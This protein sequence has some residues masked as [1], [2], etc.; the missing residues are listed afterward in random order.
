M[1]KT[2]LNILK[3]FRMGVEYTGGTF[4]KP[5]EVLVDTAEF[6]YRKIVH[7]ILAC[8]EQYSGVGTVRRQT[9]YSNA[10]GSV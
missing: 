7:L 2:S 10:E 3:H 1:N 6:V 8:S 9:D 5:F 4:H